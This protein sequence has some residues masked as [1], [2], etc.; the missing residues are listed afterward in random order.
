MLRNQK[1]HYRVHNR[2][3][4]IPILRQIKPV[5]TTPSHLRSILIL[6]T[7]PRLGIPSGLFLSG[8]PTNVLYAFLFAP[9]CATCPCYLILIYLIVLIILGEEHK[10]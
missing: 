6:S 1:V 7:Y 2:P 9:M 10:L 5:H 8:F 3:P 4:L